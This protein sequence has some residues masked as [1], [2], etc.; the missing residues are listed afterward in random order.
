MPRIYQY[1][2]RELGIATIQRLSTLAQL[3]LGCLYSTDDEITASVQAASDGLDAEVIVDDP[4]L[5]VLAGYLQAI[6][7]QPS[8]VAGE[9]DDRVLAYT[10][11]ADECLV[12]LDDTEITGAGRFRT[13]AIE[14][15]VSAL[16]CGLALVVTTS[17]PETRTAAID[18]AGTVLALFEDCVEA[19]DGIQKAFE[20]SDWDARYFSQTATYSITANLVATCVRYLLRSAYDLKIEKRFT[21][22][23]PTAPIMLAIAEYAT[24]DIDKAFSLFVRANALTGDEILLLPA[25]REVVVYV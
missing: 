3:H 20:D 8:A 7:Q 10:G 16:F 9:L 22:R 12:L 18:L 25:G 5:A 17:T 6:I 14:V 1:G 15:A 19:L 24:Q 23:E 13:A 11:L 4:S 21:L 2:D